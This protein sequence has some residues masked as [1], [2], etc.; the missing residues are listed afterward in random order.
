MV[1]WYSS[2][3]AQLLMGIKH[4][5]EQ[6]QRQFVQMPSLISQNYQGIQSF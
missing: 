5:I 6:K 1:L 2:A 3:S 4:N